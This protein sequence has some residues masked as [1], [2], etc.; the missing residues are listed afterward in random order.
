M[1]SG[2]R[3]TTSQPPNTTYA[4]NAPHERLKLFSPWTIA[5]FALAVGT[6]F[7]LV[8]PKVSL[9]QRLEEQIAAQS[10]ENHPMSQ[11]VFEGKASREQLQVFLRHQWFRTYRLYRDANLAV[12]KRKKSKRPLN[13][14]VPLQL[15][16]AVNEVCSMDFVSDSLSNG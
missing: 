7:A 15:A 2:P 9:Q 10:R 6:V 1:K 4:F 3:Q 14:R 5:G 16:K 8:Y 13:E 12:R 11:Y